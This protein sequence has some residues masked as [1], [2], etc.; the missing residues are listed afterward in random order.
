VATETITLGGRSFTLAPMPWG[1]LKRLTLAISRVGIALAA[2]LVTEETLDDMGRVLSIGLG[3]PADELEQ[4]PTDQHEVSAA[5][6]A[7]MRVSGMQQEMDF[8][9]GEAL[10]RALAST[11]P[12]A[13]S[14]STHGT[15]STP[16]P[17]PTPA[18]P[19]AS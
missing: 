9:Q 15:A 7:L 13:P 12:P 2:G 1:Q 17:P 3:L 16:T 10:R 19:G 11:Q 14:S 8:Q 4:M 6:R 18:G 5:F